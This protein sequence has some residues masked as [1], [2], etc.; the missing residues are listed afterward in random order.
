MLGIFA[1]QKEVSYT[2]KYACLVQLLSASSLKILSRLVNV[3]DRL[4]VVRKLFILMGSKWAT[5]PSKRLKIFL[6]TISNPLR[7]DL[8][9]KAKFQL[10]SFEKRW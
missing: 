1:H 3:Y 8:Y 2:C 10:T 9:L 7:S 4:K 5:H 6:S